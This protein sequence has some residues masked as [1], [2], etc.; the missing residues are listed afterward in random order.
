MKFTPSVE[1]CMLTSEIAQYIEDMLDGKEDPESFDA[2][3]EMGY[4]DAL[5]HWRKDGKNAD[6]FFSTDSKLLLRFR[7]ELE[8]QYGLPILT[9]EEGLEREK[10][11]RREMDVYR[12]TTKHFLN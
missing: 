9:E 10:K 2:L 8:R 3:P 5:L 12:M 11:L 4:A 6:S 1:L 7:S